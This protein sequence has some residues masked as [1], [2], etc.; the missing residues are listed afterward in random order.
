M[1][2]VRAHGIGPAEEG[3]GPGV[4][5]V[6]AFAIHPPIVVRIAFLGI[7]IAAGAGPRNKNAGIGVHH[8]AHPVFDDIVRL[9]EHV[10]AGVLVIMG[11]VALARGS[12]QFCQELGAGFGRGSGCGEVHGRE[13]A[14]AALVESGEDLGI[15]GVLAG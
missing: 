9:P 2:K 5:H 10:M 8:A 4:L 15:R 12:V 7:V 3:L 11:S 6:H 13:R 14:A 1:V